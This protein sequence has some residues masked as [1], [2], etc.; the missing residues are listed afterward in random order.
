VSEQRG[1][2]C[3]STHHPLSSEEHP[4]HESDGD[5]VLFA[6]ALEKNSTLHSLSLYGS[7]AVVSRGALKLTLFCFVFQVLVV[8]GVNNAHVFASQLPSVCYQTTPYT[9]FQQLGRLR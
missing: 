4:R 2:G 8:R 3:V 1:L 6:K 7:C 5:A 9:G